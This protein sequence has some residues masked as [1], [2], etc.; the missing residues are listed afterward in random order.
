MAAHSSTYHRPGTRAF[1]RARAEALQ[2]CARERLPFWVGAALQCKDLECL[3]LARW[4]GTAECCGVAGGAMHNPTQP[5]LTVLWSGGPPHT[6]RL[7]LG[8]VASAF[9]PL[10]L[11]V[12]PVPDSVGFYRAMGFKPVGGAG[13][14]W[15]QSRNCEAAPKPK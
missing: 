15:R 13:P 7:L 4:P 2:W 14:L 8:E 5:M 9:Q 10:Q 11:H 3:A 12:W 1:E 6:G